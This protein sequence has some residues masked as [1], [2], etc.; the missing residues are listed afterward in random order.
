MGGQAWDG[1][2]LR[3]PGWKQEESQLTVVNLGQS[4]LHNKPEMMT[5]FLFALFRLRAVGS[6]AQ[7]DS[8]ASGASELLAQANV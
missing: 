7:R 4:H 3:K 6:L 8:G 2:L 5:L 1:T